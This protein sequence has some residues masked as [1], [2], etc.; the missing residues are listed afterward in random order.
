MTAADDAPSMRDAHLAAEAVAHLD[1]GIVLLYG[2]VATGTATADSDIDICLIFDDLGDY[3]QRRSLKHTAQAAVTDATGRRANVHVCDRPEWRALCDCASSF[4]RHIGAYAV[5]LWER[6]PRQVDWD[7]QLPGPVTSAALAERMLDNARFALSTLGH[8]LEVSSPRLTAQPRH[9]GAARMLHR[10]RAALSALGHKLAVPASRRRARRRPHADI[11]RSEE[12]AQRARAEVCA[13]AL[14][15]I[16][17][18]LIAANHAVSGPH[19]PKLALDVAGA[20]SAMPLR[21]DERAALRAA[22]AAVDPAD[23]ATWRKV[24]WSDED[25]T[26]QPQARQLATPRH[27]RAMAQA[28]HRVASAAV[29]IIDERLG[30]D[31]SQLMREAL[32]VHREA[33]CGPA[34]LGWA[35]ALRRRR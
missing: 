20:V 8:K 14:A 9:A 5:T 30:T 35:A 12:H 21:D 7:K 22:L 23:V 1:A 19:L 4:E 3:S 6:P 11:A 15:V 18:S 28:A 16:E 25:L 32:A 17:V 26:S 31:A 27:T 10:Q 33:C 29:G 24:R 34:G 2:S 13:E